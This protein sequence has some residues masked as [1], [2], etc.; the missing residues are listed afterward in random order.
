MPNQFMIDSVDNGSQ[1][2]FNINVPVGTKQLKVML[3]WHD[4]TG[5]PANSIVLVNNL[6]ITVVD[7][8]LQFIQ[9]MGAE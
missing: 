3:Y 7:P 4:I 1:K 8:N 5:N 6:D 2:T 9:T